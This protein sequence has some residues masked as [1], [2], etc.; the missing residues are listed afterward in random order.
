MR[1]NDANDEMESLDGNKPYKY[2]NARI[3]SFPKKRA[4]CS[5]NDIL[6]R[7]C[8]FNLFASQETIRKHSIGQIANCKSISN[9]MRIG[10]RCDVQKIM[11]Q[12]HI[13]YQ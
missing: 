9:Q 5:L 11:M 2:F 4:K 6:Q 12:N 7:K 13:S 8:S 10:Q 1:K 3:P